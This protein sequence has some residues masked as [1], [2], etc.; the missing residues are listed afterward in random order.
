[1]A[2]SS[3]MCSMGQFCGG[4]RGTRG[5][6]ALRAARPDVWQ[7][8]LAPTDHCAAWPEIDLPFAEDLGS[9][10]DEPKNDSRPLIPTVSCYR[11][12]SS[13][14]MWKLAATRSASAAMASRASG[15]RASRSSVAPHS[16]V[17]PTRS[18]MLLPLP[19]IPRQSTQISA[20][21]EFASLSNLAAARR[22]S[23]YVLTISTRQRAMA[24]S[25]IVTPRPG[26]AV[27]GRPLAFTIRHRHG[28]EETGQSADEG[29]NAKVSH[30]P[31]P[32]HT[33]RP[34]RNACS[35]ACWAARPK[36]SV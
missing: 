6:T 18:R 15:P 13:S 35:A 3:T 2:A 16:A 33:F 19:L 22:W 20:R 10:N 28:G 11:R 5:V 12:A 7:R 26:D 4:S 27:D 14:G 24:T 17:R 32:G 1:M 23:P 31:P 25:S 21:K 9:P 34:T 8:V 30:H 29:L 36:P